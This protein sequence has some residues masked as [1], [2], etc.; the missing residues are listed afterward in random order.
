MGLNSLAMAR[1]KKHIFSHQI[2]AATRPVFLCQ[3]AVKDIGREGSFDWPLDEKKENLEFGLQKVGKDRLVL[4]VAFTAEM[5]S[6][7]KSSHLLATGSLVKIYMGGP[8][9]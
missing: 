3:S 2:L 5:G 9:R 4:V 8:E 6:S 7:R 1:G